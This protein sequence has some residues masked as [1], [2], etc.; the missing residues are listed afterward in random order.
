MYR[1]SFALDRTFWTFEQVGNFDLRVCRF[2]VDFCFRE[3]DGR[4]GTPRRERGKSLKVKE[5]GEETI[6]SCI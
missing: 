2:I 5:E 3:E 6:A 4:D 1:A